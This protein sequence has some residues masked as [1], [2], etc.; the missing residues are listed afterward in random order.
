MGVHRWIL[1]WANDPI[2][3]VPA[4][5]DSVRKRAARRGLVAWISVLVHGVACL[6]LMAVADGT[7][8]VPDMADRLHWV[9]AHPILWTATW[10]AW[11]GASMSLIGF[12]LVWTVD[13]LERGS[14]TTWTVGG[15]LLVALGLLFDLIGETVNMRWPLR[16]GLTVEE[17]A[18]GARLYGIASAGTANGLYCLGGIVL[19][20][21]S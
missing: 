15:F 13:I 7:E 16:Q 9:A 3:G 21:Q 17:F 4:P 1:A 2:S 11:A 19:S 14:S 8:I 6:A 18:W 10:V 12:S 5:L 20:V